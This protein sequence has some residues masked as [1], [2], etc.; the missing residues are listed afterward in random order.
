MR[1]NERLIIITS[2]SKLHTYETTATDG[3]NEQ[4]KK[5]KKRVCARARAT[6]AAPEAAA[7]VCSPAGGRAGCRDAVVRRARNAGKKCVC[8]R[9][10]FSHASYEIPAR[11]RR[12]GVVDR[13]APGP[14][15]GVVVRPM[16]IFFSVSRGKI[17]RR[18]RRCINRENARAVFPRNQTIGKDNLTVPRERTP[19]ERYARRHARVVP[20]SSSLALFEQ[21]VPAGRG[22]NFERGAAGRQRRP[23]IVE[24][25]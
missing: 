22:R 23:R 2:T 17:E 14:W 5:K 25:I 9:N 4:Q 18:K 6:T 8:G 16:K 3:E 13:F 19:L 10:D 21:V 12:C 20:S 24:K 7:A 11:R 1:E 15:G